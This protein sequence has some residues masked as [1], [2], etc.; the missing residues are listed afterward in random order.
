MQDRNTEQKKKTP[1]RHKSAAIFLTTTARSAKANC[2]SSANM[3]PKS[4]YFKGRCKCKVCCERVATV[5]GSVMTRSPD[6]KFK[7]PAA[8]QSTEAANQRPGR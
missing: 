2:R 3:V 7:L 4:F 1:K 6:S 8:A 5:I